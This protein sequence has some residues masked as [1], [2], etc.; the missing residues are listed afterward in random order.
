MSKYTD[1]RTHR[2]QGTEDTFHGNKDTED[3]FHGNKDS[4]LHLLLRGLDEAGTDRVSGG[5]MAKRENRVKG[6]V[7]QLHKHIYFIPYWYPIYIQLE[8]SGSFLPNDLTYQGPYFY[9]LGPI[10]I[11]LVM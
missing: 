1:T 8:Q 7:S 9:A 11:L 2:H 6:T 3:T 4:P 10:R 5:H